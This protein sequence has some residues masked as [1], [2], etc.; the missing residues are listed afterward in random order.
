MM[1]QSLMFSRAFRSLLWGLFRRSLPGDFPVSV[2]M[3]LML[4]LPS[5]VAY[6]FSL[7]RMGDG[8]TRKSRR[9]QHIV[10]A[11]LGN[12]LESL[13]RDWKRS[14]IN[15][16]YYICQIP[17][18]LMNTFTCTIAS[19]IYSVYYNQWENLTCPPILPLEPQGVMEY[20]TTTASSPCLY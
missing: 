9:V 14:I 4:L 16:E 2:T 20:G 11:K 15:N 3:I 10:Q 13:P 5:M 1:A 7:L 12:L 17:N 18:V 6:L 19:C 8:Q